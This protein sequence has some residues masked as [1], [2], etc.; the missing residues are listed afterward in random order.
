MCP[1]CT[2]RHKKKILLDALFYLTRHPSA[3]LDA[4]ANATD[5]ELSVLPSP[6]RG[7]GESMHWLTSGFTSRAALFSVAVI[8]MGV[9]A[10]PRSAVSCDPQYVYTTNDPASG[11]LVGCCKTDHTYRSDNATCT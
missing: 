4:G 10:V 1:F 3:V 8:G 2:L 9:L 6:Y 5:E 11:I 7:K